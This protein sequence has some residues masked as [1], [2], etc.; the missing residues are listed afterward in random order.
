MAN[1]T[2]TPLELLQAAGRQLLAEFREIKDSNP[3]AGDSGAE[4]E[5]ILKQFLRDR[6][7]RRFGIE[8]GIVLGSQG[9]VSRQT[10]LIV[11]DAMSAPVYR[12]GPRTHILPRDNVAAVIEVKS[13]LSKDQLADAVSKIAQIKR[14]PASPISGADEPVTMSPLVNASTWG[15]VFAYDAYTSI[16]TLAENLKELNEGLPSKEWTDFVIVLGKGTIGYAVQM[17]FSSQF[18]YFGGQTSDETPGFPIYLHEVVDQNVDLDLNRFFLRLMSHL[19]FFRRRTTIDFQGLLGPSP[20]QAMSVQGYQ[21]K[22]DGSA[23]PVE[24]THLA[25]TFVNP[26]LRYWVFDRETKGFVGQV[27]RWSWQ[28]GAVITYSGRIHPR[29]VF[30]PLF[31]ALGHREAMFMPSGAPGQMWLSQVLPISEEAFSAAM[32]RLGDKLFASRM[33]GDESPPAK[34]AGKPPPR[35]K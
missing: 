24:A 9:Q 30:S 25:E 18:G 3:H 17:P 1:E 28:D 4:A 13:K 35:S 14:M 26:T 7:P 23:V 15:C 11:Y 31:V 8:S 21:F 20:G 12:K 16:E 33:L 27:C 5:E 34:F 22:I 29:L 32:K 6:L 10:D 19:A 2:L